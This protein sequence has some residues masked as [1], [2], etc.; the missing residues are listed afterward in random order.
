MRV[1]SSS[2]EGYSSVTSN[3]KQRSNKVNTAVAEESRATIGSTWQRS[4]Q[5]YLKI[6]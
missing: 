4:A 5:N 1:S 2:K 3:A 6:N